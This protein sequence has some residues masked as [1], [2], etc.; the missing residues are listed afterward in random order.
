ME[1]RNQSTRD[2]FFELYNTDFVNEG[3]YQ[4]VIQTDL[5]R[6]TEIIKQ[7]INNML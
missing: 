7:I 5:L 4:L 1:T 3:N 2:R 6:T